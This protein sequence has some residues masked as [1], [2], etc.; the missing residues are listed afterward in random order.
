MQSEVLSK[1][2]QQKNKKKASSEKITRNSYVGHKDEM[3]KWLW[4]CY[5]NDATVRFHIGRG[6]R[7]LREE[8]EELNEMG[9]GEEVGGEKRQRGVIWKGFKGANRECKPQRRLIHRDSL[10]REDRKPEKRKIESNFH[11]LKWIQ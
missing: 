2:D 5:G 8:E 1:G 6:S 10:Q 11:R 9:D 7:V 3:Q 4:D